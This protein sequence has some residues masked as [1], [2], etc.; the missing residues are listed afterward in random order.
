MSGKADAGTKSFGAL[1]RGYR[2]RVGLT[3]EELAARAGLYAQQISQLER[4]V[5]RRPQSRT[6][7]YLAE[8][9]KLDARDR[10]AFTAAARG[11]PSSAGSAVATS[12][13]LL[14]S[15]VTPADAEAHLASMP[16]DVLPNRGALPA[17]S[18]MPLAPNPLFV[19]RGDEL[20][21]VAAALR[22]A[23]TTVAL[24]QV[25]ASTGV[26]GL[27][28]TQIAVEFVHRYGRY[29]AGG[30]FWLSFANADEIPLQ[31]AACAEPGLEARPLEER[32]QRVRDAWQDAV[33]RLLVFDNCEE[34]ALLDAWRPVSG[35]C[36]V[37]VTSRRS[38]WSPTL[39]VKALPLDILPRADSKDKST[40]LHRYILSLADRHGLDCL[41][42]SDAFDA[43]AVDEFRLSEWDPH[44]SA[45]GHLAI[46]EALRDALS[47]RRDLPGFPSRAPTRRGPVPVP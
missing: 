14:A 36:R 43:L 19:G 32:V 1:L 44:P 33:P 28:K 10:E 2:G 42:V 47:R 20:L 23:D 37:L 41:D 24:G 45:R 13:R 17:G 18:R 40:R 9:L 5:V 16:T 25:V 6:I 11:L 7:E 39:G 31:L 38:H 34:E 35:G 29:F 30:A 21:Q 12:G 8:A 46:F 27:G 26:G 22:S 15:P 3:Q 4:D